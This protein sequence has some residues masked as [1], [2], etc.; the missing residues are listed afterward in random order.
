VHHRIWDRVKKLQLA[1]ACRELRELRILEKKPCR[2]ARGETI[3]CEHAEEGQLH[4]MGQVMS[5]VHNGEGFILVPP[6]DEPAGIVCRRLGQLDDM[7]GGD[8]MVG[9]ENS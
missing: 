9:L 2:P 8:A 5:V 6:G 4:N 7:N 1:A 3:E